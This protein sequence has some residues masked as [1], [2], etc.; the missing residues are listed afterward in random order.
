[1]GCTLSFGYNA[2][3]GEMKQHIY[4]GEKDHALFIK[5]VLDGDLEVVTEPD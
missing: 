5:A 3:Q 4:Q 1:M 2:I